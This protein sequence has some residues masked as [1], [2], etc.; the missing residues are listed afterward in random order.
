MFQ[1]LGCRNLLWT[2]EM[3]KDSIGTLLEIVSHALKEQPAIVPEVMRNIGVVEAE[4]H[5][6]LSEWAF[7]SFAP[8]APNCVKR[9]VMLR[10]S[11]CD[12]IWVET[13]TYHGDTSEFLAESAVHVYTTEP[14]RSFYERAK[15][16]FALNNKVSV[17]NETSETFLPNLLPQLAG[18]VCFWL[19]GH[20]SGDDT[21]AGPNDTPLREE[22]VAIAQSH[23]RFDSMAILIDDIRLAGTRHVYGDY[24]TLNELVSFAVSLSLDWHI[25]HDIFIARSKSSVS[26]G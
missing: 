9:Q 10:N 21:F 8:P 7:R 4:T 24:P 17:Y 3:R 19:D 23:G 5:L 18:N 20:F 11:L 14:Q 15:E 6:D 1:P 12:A 26:K 22:L 2:I 25:E 16:R 13:G